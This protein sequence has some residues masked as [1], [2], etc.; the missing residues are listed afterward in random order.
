MEAKLRSCERRRMARRQEAL[1]VRMMPA[2]WCSYA[3]LR[4][5]D[6]RLPGWVRVRSEG[7]RCTLVAREERSAY[8]R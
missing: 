2:D 4:A 7:G 6:A 8:D 5:C 3:L 1:P